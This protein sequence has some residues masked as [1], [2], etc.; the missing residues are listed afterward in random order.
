[1]VAE[2]LKFPRMEE[3]RNERKEVEKE[4]KNIREEGKEG[5]IKEERKVK[6]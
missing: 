2:M 6:G 5:D 3:G 1:M 4:G